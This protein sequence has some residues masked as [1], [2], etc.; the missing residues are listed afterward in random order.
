MKKICLIILAFNLISCSFFNKVK[1]EFSIKNNS[2]KTI[3]EIH[4]KTEYDSISLKELKPGESFKK[5]IL[6][7][8]LTESEQEESRGFYLSFL[9]TD[10]DKID[11]LWC[12]DIL[13]YDNSNKKVI[14][15]VTDNDIKS[16]I[17]GIECF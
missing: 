6:Y 8:D 14:I 5:E 4:F 1:V 11:K 13:S 15:N 7:C 3:S 12:S 9:R 16:D 2:T 17:E 10:K